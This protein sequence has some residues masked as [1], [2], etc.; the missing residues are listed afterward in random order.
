MKC[1]TTIVTTF[2][3]TNM[4]VA[5]GPLEDNF[6]CSFTNRGL[7]TSILVAGRVTISHSHQ[8]IEETLE[9]ATLA[10]CT[11]LLASDCRGDQCLYDGS[12]LPP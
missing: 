11:E 9:D 3:R 8:V 12:I 2:P 1:A 10:P 5:N 7:S 6:P 4:E